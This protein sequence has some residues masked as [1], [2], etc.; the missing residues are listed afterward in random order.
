MSDTETP[1]FKM[2]QMGY[3]GSP[4]KITIPNVGEFTLKMGASVTT[5]YGR[6]VTTVTIKIPNE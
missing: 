1:K 6:R 5:T 3:S 2:P 4:L